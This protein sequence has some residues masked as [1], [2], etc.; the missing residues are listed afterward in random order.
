MNIKLI[1]CLALVLSGG[2]L[3]AGCRGMGTQQ[4]KAFAPTQTGELENSSR[5]VLDVTCVSQT[6]QADYNLTENLSMLA[7]KAKYW[8]LNMTLEVNRVVKGNFD[9]DML[10]IHWLRQPTPEQCAA[11]GTSHQPPLGDVKHLR[12][13]FD[14][15]SNGHFKNLKIMTRQ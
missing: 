13:G 4:F 10:Q 9:K 6:A 7:P 5:N 12:I 2:L 8:K 11:L 15:Y 1:L 3:G 14:D